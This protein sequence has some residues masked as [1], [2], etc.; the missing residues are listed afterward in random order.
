MAGQRGRVESDGRHRKGLD[1]ARTYVPSDERQ[2]PRRLVSACSDL[3][4]EA[5]SAVIAKSST[6]A[7]TRKPSWSL[8]S[9]F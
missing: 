1:K 3:F 5:D 7:S 9:T 2:G 8:P 4:K 6:V